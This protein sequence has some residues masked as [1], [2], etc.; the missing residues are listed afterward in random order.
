M[1]EREAD[2]EEPA[3]APRVH[4]AKP[5]ES[6]GISTPPPPQGPPALLATPHGSEALH[7]LQ[8]TKPGGSPKTTPVQG[9]GLLNLSVKSKHLLCINYNK[10]AVSLR[11]LGCNSHSQQVVCMIY[12]QKLM[13]TFD[14]GSF[15]NRETM[16]LPSSHRLGPR[17]RAAP[18]QWYQLG[19]G[20]SILGVNRAEH[21][22]GSPHPR[23]VSHSTTLGAEQTL[24]AKPQAHG[25]SLMH[26]LATDTVVGVN[27]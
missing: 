3:T 21:S 10:S 24:G 16:L 13:F 6:T 20:G 2:C 22:S 25:H 12:G 27:T 11:T 26:I 14:A 7:R 5:L 1:L 17:A 18:P 8:F 23:P 4:S 15:I 9:S 19:F